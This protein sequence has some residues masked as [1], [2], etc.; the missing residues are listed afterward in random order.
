MGVAEDKIDKLINEKNFIN[1]SLS[2]IKIEITALEREKDDIKKA[3]KARCDE[4]DP[5]ERST[6]CLH[7]GRVQMRKIRRLL[8]KQ[9]ELEIRLNKINKKIHFAKIEL[10]QTQQVTESTLSECKGTNFT[11]WTY[12]KGTYTWSNGDKYFGEF[13]D[14]KQHGV[15]IYTFS[16][17]DKYVG[18][19]KDGKEHGQGTYT[20]ANGDKYF[21]EYKDGKKHGQ[22]IEIYLGGDKYVGEYKNGLPNGQGTFTRAD[23]DKYVGEYKDG[24]RHGQGILTSPDGDKYVGEYKDG[25]KHGQGTYTKSDGTVEKGIWENGKLVEPN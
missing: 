14:G 12:C 21:G 7:A 5:Q 1:K 18:E 11:T 17:G 3:V 16:D 20:W 9:H 2:E 15:G 24:K 4:M 19:F 23:G 25:K 13:K 22:G 8:K 10:T 6:A